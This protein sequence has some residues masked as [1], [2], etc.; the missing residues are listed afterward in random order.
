MLTTF[1]QLLLKHA[2]ERPR[3]RPCA[4]KNMA[5]GKPHS[6]ADLVRLVEQVAHA[7]CTWR[8]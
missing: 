2:A 5:S 6:W 7:A 1:P 8:A 4:K 3:P